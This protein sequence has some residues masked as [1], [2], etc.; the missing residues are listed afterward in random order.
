MRPAQ[1]PEISSAA[2]TIGVSERS[3][4]RRLT[5]DGTSYRDVVRSALEG[6]AGRMLRD[7]AYTIKQIASALGFAHA[8]AFHRAFKRWTGM[9]P[10]EYRRSAGVR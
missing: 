10:G 4:R 7:P 6:S 9:T 8:A 2:R 1:L 3:L 5:A